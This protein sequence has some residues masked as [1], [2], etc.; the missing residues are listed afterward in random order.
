[1]DTL[2]V[3]ICYTNGIGKNEDGKK[4]FELFMKSAIG[5]YSKGQCVVGFYYSNGIGTQQDYEK[6]MV[7]KIGQKWG[8]DGA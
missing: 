7:F 2:R 6:A 4:A 1:M 3:S 5:G 8:C